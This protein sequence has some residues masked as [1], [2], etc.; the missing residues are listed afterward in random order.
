MAIV[1]GLRHRLIN[2][3]IRLLLSEG[4]ASLHWMDSGRQH[5]P[6]SV[7]SEALDSDVEALPNIVTVSYEDI[8]SMDYELGQ[9]A[10]EHSF[11]FYV[12]VYAESSAVGKHLAG[13]VRDLLIGNFHSLGYTKP[14]LE[15]VDLRDPLRPVFTTVQFEDVQV[16]RSRVFNKP[17]QKFWWVVAFVVVDYYGS[18]EE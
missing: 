10:T 5:R 1:G 18:D 14:A 16:D 6:L 4:L 2:D 15:C 9:Y 11:E 13:D 17:Y 12:D 7:Q 3:N 8:Q